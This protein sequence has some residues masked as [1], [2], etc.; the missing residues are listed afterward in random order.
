MDLD[1]SK[2]YGSAVSGV[3]NTDDHKKIDFIVKYLRKYKVTCKKAL[4]RGSR[5]HMELYDEKTG[6]RKFRDRVL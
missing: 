1:Q 6:G 2:L 5:A 4:T 3:I